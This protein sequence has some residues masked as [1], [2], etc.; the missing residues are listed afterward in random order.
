MYQAVASDSSLSNQYKVYGVI[1]EMKDIY[2]RNDTLSAPTGSFDRTHF[3]DHPEMYHSS[4]AHCVAPYIHVLVNSIYW[5]HRFPRLLTHD[6][7]LRLYEEG[8]ER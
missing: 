2:Q 7:M 3:M 1:P 6:D 8:N 4:F 5:E